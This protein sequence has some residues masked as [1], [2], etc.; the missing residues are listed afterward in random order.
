MD[1]VQPML[2]GGEIMLEDDKT[3]ISDVLL[4]LCFSSSSSFFFFFF[5]FFFSQSF[6]L[7]SLTL[8]HSVSH[9]V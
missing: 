5:F 3:S 4:S 8:A 9:L 7:F 2:S 1:W 6:F